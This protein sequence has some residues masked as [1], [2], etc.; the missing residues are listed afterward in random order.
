MCEL[1]LG[2]FDGEGP[3]ETAKDLA[4][5]FARAAAAVESGGRYVLD[6]HIERGCA[7]PSR[8]LVSRKT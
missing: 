3:I 1:A 6:V 4:E 7:E 5:A 8:T 2:S